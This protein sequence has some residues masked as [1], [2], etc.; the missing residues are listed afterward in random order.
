MPSVMQMT[1][2]ISLAAASRIPSAGKRRRNKDHRRIRARLFYG[3]FDGV[4]DRPAFVRRA[5]L[6]GSYSANNDVV[7]K[8]FR[9]FR[10]A[11]GVEST[12]TT[13]NSLHD[14]TR[15]LIDQNCH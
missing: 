11:L 10:A 4:E 5:A 15:I 12:F 1:S 8:L 3:L 13:R 2:G 7:A 6:T 14:E 9:V